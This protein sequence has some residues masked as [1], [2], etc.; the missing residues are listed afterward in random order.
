[1]IPTGDFGIMKHEAIGLVI[2][3]KREQELYP[4]A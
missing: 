1:M 4:S 2:E 3:F